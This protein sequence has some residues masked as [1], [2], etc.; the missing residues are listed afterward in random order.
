MQPE[1]PA[2]LGGKIYEMMGM[3]LGGKWSTPT[4][5]FQ[6]PSGTTQQPHH[7]PETIEAEV[8]WYNIWLDALDNF[9]RPNQGRDRGDIIEVKALQL[10]K[11]KDQD[12]KLLLER[13]LKS[14]N[15]SWIQE[16]C[17]TDTWIGK[18]SIWAFIDLSAGPFSWGTA[19]GG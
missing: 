12:M 16:E 18:D 19:V 5:Q 14:G 9:G 10:L 6:Q 7:V 11:G 13:A 17:L 8:E 4:N 3:A 2:Q 15:F 1:N